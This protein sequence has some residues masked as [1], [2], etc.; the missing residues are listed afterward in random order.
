MF[1]TV[2]MYLAV[3]AF[4]GFSLRKVYQY[5]RHPLPNR[6][7]L[8][9][10]PWEPGGRGDYGGSYHEEAEWWTGPRQVSLAGGYKEMFKDILFMRSLFVN[11]RKLWWLSYSM[12][13]GIYLL[14]LFTVLLLAGALTELAGMKLIAS[15]DAVSHPW[16]VFVHLSTFVTGYCGAFLA[17]GG[18]AALFFYRISDGTLRRYTGLDEYYNLFLI[19]IAAV[20]GLVAWSTDP[21]FGYGR[22]L[23][24][25][26][27]TLAPIRAGAAVTVHILLFGALLISIPLTKMSHYV[28]KYFAYHRV[29]WDNEP[30]L[31]GSVMEGKVRR[32]LDYSPRDRWS[33]PH[34]NSNGG[35]DNN[36]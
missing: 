16:A 9:P 7:E 2:Y 36:N 17:A 10:V 33:S 26:M 28:G 35:Q 24:T 19:F 29:L 21:G 4:A 23:M 14:G 6:W 34:A 22:E 11:R 15:S 32:N 5:A 18:S 30:N 8:Y 3:A 25:A 13:L 31:R 27:L 12:H 1:L 20:S